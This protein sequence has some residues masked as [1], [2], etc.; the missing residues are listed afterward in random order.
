MFRSLGA[1]VF[2]WFVLTLWLSTSGA[3]CTYD[4]ETKYYDQIIDH[5]NFA[6]HDNKTYKQRYL[7]S[8]KHWKVGKGPI[9]FYTGNEGPINMFLENTGFMYDIAPEFSALLIFAEHRFYGE[10]LPF[11]NQ[12][13]TPENLGLLTVEQ[14]LADYAGLIVYL[15]ESLKCPACRVVTFGG[16]YGGMLSAYMRF[17][18]PNVVD[19]A[20]ASSAPIYSVAGQGSQTYFFADVTKAFES[21]PSI[22]PDCVTTVKNAFIQMNKLADD[23]KEGLSNISST[24]KLC[25][26]L[27][28]KSQI[29]HLQGWVRNAFTSMAMSNYPYATSF[30]GQLPAWPVNVSCGLIVKAQSSNPMQGLAEAAILFYNGTDGKLKCMD[31]DLEYIECADPTGCGLGNN[32][33]AWDW[34]ACTEITMPEGSNNVTDMFPALPLTEQIR[35]AYCSQK[36]KVTPKPTWLNIIMWGKDIKA[37]SN[38]VFCNGALDPWRDG[39]VLVNPD[40]ADLDVCLIYEGAHHLDLRGENEADPI[41]VKNARKLH[42]RRISCWIKE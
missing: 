37:A 16:S 12:S 13:F 5:F 3:S 19:G 15:K 4:Y 39:G 1:V 31:P 11:G 34:Q 17:K 10:S 40:P 24:F 36:W 25:K 32:A 18:Y 41:Y 14:A 21:V 6:S 26:S 30:L 23:G 2:V 9:F 33:K 22:G 20:I 7:V 8:D 38:I 28:S 35:E 42:R 27:T 29:A